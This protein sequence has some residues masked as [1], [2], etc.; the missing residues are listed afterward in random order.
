MKKLFVLLL[1]LL[2]LCSAAS[3]EYCATA[4]A[5]EVNPEH[6]VNVAVNARITDCSEDGGTLTLMLIAP[7]R[8][9]R[10]EIESLQSGDAIFTQGQEVCIDSVT[11]KYGYIVFNEGDYEFSEGSVWLYEDTDESYW[12][13]EYDDHT[14]IEIAELQIPVTDRLIFLDGINPSSGEGLILPAVHSAGEFVS[15]FRSEAAGGGPG[16]DVNNVTVVFD[17]E[18]RLAVVS[19]Y[20]VPWQ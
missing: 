11:E 16:F 9:R 19:R 6:L 3:A 20:Y 18:G 15:L 5:V 12:I 4:M 10:D 2:F 14:W 8:Y 7:E 13:A 17:A 1:S